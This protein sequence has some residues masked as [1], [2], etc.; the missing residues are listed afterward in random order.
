MGTATLSRGDPA[1]VSYYCISNHAT[2]FLSA[3]GLTRV[4]AKNFNPS[5]Q[6]RPTYGALSGFHTCSVGSVSCAF[7]WI[8]APPPLVG[9]NACFP[10]RASANAS[11]PSAHGAKGMVSEPASASQRVCQACRTTACNCFFIIAHAYTTIYSVCRTHHILFINLATLSVISL[12]NRHL[13]LSF[14]ATI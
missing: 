7:A 3:G 6:N 1:L 9:K 5:H 11:V 4:Y 8:S 10:V 13:V 12:I 14:S 2:Q